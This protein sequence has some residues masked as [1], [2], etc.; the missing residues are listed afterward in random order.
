[1]LSVWWSCI[2]STLRKNHYII[3]EERQPNWIQEMQGITLLIMVNKIIG[4]IINTWLSDFIS[5]RKDIE[6]T[7]HVWTKSISHNWHEL[8]LCCQITVE[9]GVRQVWFLSPLLFN[10]AL[11]TVNIIGIK[12]TLKKSRIPHNWIKNA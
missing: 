10:I 6:H 7:N 5:P 8:Q 3:T 9:E 11:Y 4:Q 2:T 1:M 12:K